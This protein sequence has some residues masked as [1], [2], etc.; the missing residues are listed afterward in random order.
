MA[1]RIP[2]I[3]NPSA[4]QIQELPNADDLVLRGQLKMTG[5]TSGASDISLSGG[6]DAKSVIGITST[7][8]N[9]SLLGID[10]RNNADDANLPVA[11]FKVGA[12]DK[13]EFVSKGEITAE[14]EITAVQPTCLLTVPKPYTANNSDHNTTPHEGG[15]NFKPISFTNTTTNVNCTTSLA[16]DATINSGITSIT[17]PSA[18][19]YL[20]SACISGEK[21][22]STNE[23]DQIRFGLSKSGVQQFPSKLTFPT[24]VFGNSTGQE[25]NAT[26]TLPLTLSASDTLSVHLS[27]IGGSS[28]AIADGYFSVTKL[29]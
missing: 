16:S 18:G 15:T 22:G 2:L 20:V 8:S 25:F 21:S 14:G 12:S 19:T 23:D 11:E 24:F 17:V 1:D 29:H 26:F 5:T 3:V 27:H 7:K 28:A 4:E 13:I 6:T 10:C 9:L